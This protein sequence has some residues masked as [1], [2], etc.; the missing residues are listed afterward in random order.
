ML[1]DVKE[2]KRRRKALGL[3]QKKL[4]MLA[5]VSQSVVA[6]IESGNVAPSYSIVKRLF[7]VFEEMS[8]Q[9]AIKSRLV[10]KVVGGAQMFS[11]LGSCGNLDIGEGD[12]TE[13]KSALIKEGISAVASDIRGSHSRTSSTVGAGMKGAILTARHSQIYSSIITR[14]I[15]SPPYSVPSS[16]KS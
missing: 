8:K 1:P 11:I 5:G 9:G 14:I 6:K 16:T 3:T 4:A 7:D 12:I 13:L 15:S 10:I 2:I